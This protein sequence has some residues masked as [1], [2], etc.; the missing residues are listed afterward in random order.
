M[1]DFSLTDGESTALS[2]HLK[3]QQQPSAG[4]A[5]NREATAVTSA[6]ELSAFAAEKARRLLTEKLSC[7]GCHRL[8]GI[9]GVVGPDL[10]DAGQRLE[11]G[12][13]DAIIRDPRGTTPH[14]IMP[15]V[16]LPNE[17]ASLLAGYLAQRG[18]SRVPGTP[19]NQLY[20]SP[21]DDRLPGLE[22]AVA[23]AAP[24]SF[25]RHCAPCHGIEGRGDGFNA[26]FI[27]PAKPTVFADR[28]Y[29]SRRPDDTLFD[30]IHSGGAILNR[31]RL[32]PPW[33][34]TLPPAEIRALVRHLRDLCGCD[35]PPWS[36]DGTTNVV[37][38]R[39]R[40]P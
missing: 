11:R 25:V 8:D 35:G 1:P 27:L 20:L 18:T 31:S 26:P 16:P 5:A 24:A 21:M 9:G 6:A 32:M 15:Q 38:P 29:L 13:L 33:G 34:A 28:A 7:L 12:Y 39:A 4:P 30:G 40:A 10:S 19:T 3:N 37:A 23:R 22:P 14:S 36:R 17:T 2:R